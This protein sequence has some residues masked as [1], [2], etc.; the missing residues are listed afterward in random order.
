MS[1]PQDRLE[2]E[3][4]AALN[5]ALKAQRE[6]PYECHDCAA[7][8]GELHERGCDMER[9]PS[10]GGQLISC[11]CD[12]PALDELTDE[13]RIPWICYPNICARCGQLWPEL[14]EVAHEQWL[15]YISPSG[16]RLLCGEC[17][18]SIKDLIDSARPVGD[19]SDD[20]QDAA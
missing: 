2:D 1:R 16:E 11:D 5:V 13:Q 19:P 18:V 10:C 15:A 3:F 14:F 20:G 8:E 7:N 9:C 17:Y 12:G 4:M 6:H